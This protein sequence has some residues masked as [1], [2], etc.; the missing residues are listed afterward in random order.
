MNT[1]HER[2]QADQ[3]EAPPSD[4]RQ[5]LPRRQPGQQAAGRQ[6][7]RHQGANPAALV[8]RDELLHE[9]QVDRVDAG[10]AEADED[11]EDHQEQP[12][13]DETVLPWREIHYAG[14]ECDRDRR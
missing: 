6:Q 4:Y 9:R 12:T 14:G 3:K 7:C 5:Q 11:A 10:V 2:H 1:K 13:R 8:G